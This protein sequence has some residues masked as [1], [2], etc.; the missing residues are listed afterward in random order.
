VE[1]IKFKST[2][3][4][5]QLTVIVPLVAYR[6]RILLNSSIKIAENLQQ[7]ERKPSLLI[8]CLQP[9]EIVLERPSKFSKT[10]L[11]VCVVSAEGS[12]HGG[13]GGV[14]VGVGVYL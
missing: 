14:M 6:S 7:K 2:L 1:K 8:T 9:K 5:I 13:G 4:K 11:Q 3:T 12:W 10:T